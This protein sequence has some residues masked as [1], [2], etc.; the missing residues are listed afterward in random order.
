M[1]E[2]GDYHTGPSLR[3]GDLQAHPNSDMFPPTR[4][5]PVGQASKHISLWVMLVQTT[6]TLKEQ[7]PGLSSIL[8]KGREF[9]LFNFLILHV[10]IFLISN[11]YVKRKKR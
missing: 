7:H 5:L 2:V 6:T 1:Q 11:I 10:K 9:T 3:I 4:P 8:H